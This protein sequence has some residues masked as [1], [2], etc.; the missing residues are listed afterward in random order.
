MESVHHVSASSKVL[1]KKARKMVPPMLEQFHKGSNLA[2]LALRSDS[3]LT[4]NLGQHGRVAVI[5]GSL[6]FVA[7]KPN[8]RIE[9][10]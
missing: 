3:R 8:I 6:E 5:G 4:S 1:L 10:N 9:T 2:A 7:P